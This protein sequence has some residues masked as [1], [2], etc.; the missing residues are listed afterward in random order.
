MK[1]CITDINYARA[2]KKFEEE[3]DKEW[4]SILLQLDC[5]QSQLLHGNR[6][7]PKIVFWVYVASKTNSELEKLSY[8]ALHKWQLV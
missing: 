1:Y 2:E 4:N 8:T 7:R 6:L 5:K 3:F